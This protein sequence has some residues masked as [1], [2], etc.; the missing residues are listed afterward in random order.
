MAQRVRVRHHPPTPSEP[1]RTR[2]RPCPSSTG[3]PYGRQGGAPTRS[4]CHPARDGR[5]RTRSTP[6]AGHRLP[7]PSAPTTPSSSA[8][9]PATPSSCQPIGAPSPTAPASRRPRR[10]GRAP[11]R[12]NPAKASTSSTVRSSSVLAPPRR[13]AVA[14]WL[15]WPLRL[16]QRVSPLNDDDAV[17]LVRTASLPGQVTRN[18]LLGRAVFLG[19]HRLFGD[20][21]SAVGRGDPWPDPGGHDCRVEVG[22][23]CEASLGKPV[24][25]V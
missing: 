19:A 22:R 15:L 10:A 17:Q 9:P 11:P 1:A 25:E 7:A 23:E 4:P 13:V 20:L 2:H 5:P 14:M 3:T 18:R 21:A 6:P 16:D 8:H 12:R 24:I